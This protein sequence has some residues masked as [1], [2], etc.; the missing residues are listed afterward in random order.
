MPVGG[1]DFQAAML[2]SKQLLGYRLL[3][4]NSSAANNHPTFTKKS[5]LIAKDFFTDRFPANANS[6]S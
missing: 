4:R 3:Y 2:V 1:F 6:I 5:K